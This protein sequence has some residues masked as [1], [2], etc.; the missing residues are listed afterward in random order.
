VRSAAAKALGDIGDERA[1][2]ALNEALEDDFMDVR[3][4][5]AWAI[6]QM[7]KKKPSGGRV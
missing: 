6:K 5:A 3:Q 1:M 4:L 2:T 7:R